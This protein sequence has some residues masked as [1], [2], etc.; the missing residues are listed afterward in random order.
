MSIKGQ[1]HG[2]KS[3]CSIE[4]SSNTV[5]AQET[6]GNTPSIRIGSSHE[7]ERRSCE[8]RDID[9][10]QGFDVLGVLEECSIGAR[11]R[12]SERRKV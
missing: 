2:H 9:G 4:T 3:T 8:P 5:I 11:K 12:E 7:G 1:M 10:K 6:C